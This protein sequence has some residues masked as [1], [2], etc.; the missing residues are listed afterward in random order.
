M[1]GA[2]LGVLTHMVRALR[3]A[4]DPQCLGL[5][6]TIRGRAQLQQRLTGP[7]ERSFSA[8]RRVLGRVGRGE[9]CLQDQGRAA[10]YGG[11]VPRA[12]ALFEA[13]PPEVDRYPGVLV[14]QAQALRM[15]GRHLE[16]VSALR[17]AARLA[18]AMR[19]EVLVHAADCA[20]WMEDPVQALKL[21]EQVTRSG[22]PR[23]CWPAR[24]IELQARLNLGE[25]PEDLFLAS[26]MLS[27]GCEQVGWPLTALR[28]RMAAAQRLAPT[29]ARQLL[30]GVVNRRETGPARAEV[31]LA[32]ALLAQLVGRRRSV[33]AHCRAGLRFTEPHPD[34][35]IEH[36]AETARTAA[37]LAQLGLTVS[38]HRG[39]RST[40][41][42]S[43]HLR[44]SPPPPMSELIDRLA[45]D[46]LVSF[47]H[48]GDQLYALTVAGGRVRRWEIERCADQL[49]DLAFALGVCG[50]GSMRANAAAL[51]RQAAGELSQ[52]LFQQVSRA[53]ADRRLVVI[54]AGQLHGVPWAQLPHC[55]ERPTT[56]APSIAH[57]LHRSIGPRT[58]AV[59]LYG[60][61]LQHAAEEVSELHA[62][63]GGELLRLPT[64]PQALSAMDGAD[65]VHLAAH[66]DFHQGRPLYS[67]IQLSGG[68]LLGQQLEQLK[69]APRLVVLA[70]C[71]AGRSAV[72]PG[73]RL[74]GF[75]AALLSAGAHTII[76]SPVPVS[77]D[78]TRQL[79]AEFHRLLAGGHPP[80]AALALAQATHSESNFT[81][82][83]AGW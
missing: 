79:M 48:R 59:W 6:L 42:W 23:W 46:A 12:L 29:Q 37:R 33:L 62:G 55:R 51:V 61:K 63:H 64:V 16:A 41:R 39:P 18:P 30:L 72:R 73:D 22:D 49:R 58:R 7:A 82:L 69:S 54:P 67:G 11:D 45:D 60:P 2:D 9:Y 44:G 71:H 21:A 57:W 53:V 24:A 10:L 81:C 35:S 75:S 8:A 56:V 27:I 74:V 34:L 14:D 31:S 1:S 32:K 40:L 52:R 28:L 5:A 20:L 17:T 36:K 70:A 77:D 43:E 80:A 83:G 13:V 3:D 78:G 26:H 66:G 25:L 15:A 65:L 50:D 68:R 38:W 19:S 47:V 4:R 76:S